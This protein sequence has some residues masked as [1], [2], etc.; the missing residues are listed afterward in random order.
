M[1]TEDY[2]RFVFQFVDGENI[3]DLNIKSLRIQMSIVSQEPTLF[4]SSIEENI[5]YGLGRKATH[6]EV[7]NAAKLANI[8]DFIMTL[9]LVS[10][11]FT[12][13]F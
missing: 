3:E 9:P 10:V 1:S 5:M 7:V 6:E 11:F 12:C 13:T 8:H 2:H 4:D